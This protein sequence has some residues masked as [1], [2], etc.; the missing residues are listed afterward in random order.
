M[1]ETPQHQ[2]GT[3]EQY[4]R[5]G[6]LRDDQGIAQSA[7]A[8]PGSGRAASFAQCVG[9]LEG[10]TRERGKQAEEDGGSHRD[11]GRDDGSGTVMVNVSIIGRSGVAAAFSPCTSHR[12]SSKPA[13]PPANAS[14]RLSVIIWRSRRMRLAPRAE[15]T[16]ISRAVRPTCQEPARQVDAR[17]QQYDADAG[18]EH[19]H[20]EPD[21]RFDDV[22]PQRDQ[23]GA[24]SLARGRI[25]LS[26][27]VSDRGNAC[28]RLGQ[29]HRGAQT[30][31]RERS[32]CRDG[33]ARL[34]PATK[35]ATAATRRA[36]SATV[37]RREQPRQS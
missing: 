30:S 29:R 5:Q 28:T 20:A 31:D 3:G 17:D 4:D 2:A 26:D 23:I 13:A 32:C 16:A 19:E 10:R 6:N 14:T 8:A 37:D 35:G 15:R 11:P 7:G 1:D 27:T 18:E 24:P 22:L 34:R 25:L 33:S 36:R 21:F 9:G 12:A